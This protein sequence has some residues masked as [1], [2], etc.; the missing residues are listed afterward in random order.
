[1]NRNLTELGA[2]HPTYVRRIRCVLSLFVCLV[3][4]VLCGPAAW[5][6]VGAASLS[7][8]VQ[9]QTGA[10]VPS[11][12]VT[13]QN[14]ASGA[15]RTLQSNNSG[16]FTFSAVPSGDYKLTV[17][18]AGFTQLVRPAIHLNPGDS[19]SLSDL[20]LTV[21]DVNQSV[22]VSTTVAGLPLDSGQLSSTISAND[23]NILSV[24]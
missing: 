4:A 19:L 13:I 6:Q 18:H 20:S 3:L 7:G 15:Q 8:I 11:A 23:L 12:T 22:T 14:T 1:M 10:I 21:G 9:D 5:A 17:Q 16:S 24:V 2:A